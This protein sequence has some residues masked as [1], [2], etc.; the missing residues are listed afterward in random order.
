M[1]DKCRLVGPSRA[2]PCQS[3][4]RPRCPP[5][6]TWATLLWFPA[7]APRDKASQH[8]AEGTD[9]LPFQGSEEP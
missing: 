9:W 4:D 2:G 7:P 6:S 1:G 5:S 8:W 3:E